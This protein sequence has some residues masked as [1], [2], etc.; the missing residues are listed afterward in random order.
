MRR[1]T[2]ASRL[3]FLVLSAAMLMAYPSPVALAQTIPPTPDPVAVTLDPGST[4]IIVNDVTEQQCL[5]Q[6]TCT[7]T[8]VPALVSLLARARA[9]GVL[10][11]F[12]TPGSPLLPELGQEPGEPLIP[13]FG[14]DRFF[15][16]AMDDTLRARGIT[17]VIIAG[18]RSNGSVLYTAFAAGIRRYTV[19]VPVDA[20]SAGTE[21]AD[22]IGRY[23]LLDQ[24]GGNTSNQPLVP[25]RVT[26]SR[27]D[28]I[29]FE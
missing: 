6:P 19:V 4:A 5:P 29:S 3:A 11:I 9:A 20:T 14:Q 21:T 24:L 18:W 16:T 25:N 7:G 22:A 12:S 27:T 8:M 17:T 15:S 28:L 2:T 26:L 23:Q 10:V 13:G 1:A